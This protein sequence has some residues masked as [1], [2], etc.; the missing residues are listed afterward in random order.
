MH[1]C[2]YA[3]M[4]V[5][6]YICMDVYMCVCMRVCIYACMQV[7]VHAAMRVCMYACMRV[8]VYACMHAYACKRMYLFVAGRVKARTPSEILYIFVVHLTQCFLL[9]HHRKCHRAP[10]RMQSGNKSLLSTG[11]ENDRGRERSHLSKTPSCMDMAAGRLRRCP[12]RAE[13]RKHECY[14]CYGK[15]GGKEGGAWQR[16]MY[17]MGCVDGIPYCIH[18]RPSCTLRSCTSTNLKS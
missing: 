11:L 9:H 4:R 3:C 8:C 6:V 17:V 10:N 12:E 5:C 16:Q 1:A 13:E 15:E 18:R 14:E 7:C 2:L